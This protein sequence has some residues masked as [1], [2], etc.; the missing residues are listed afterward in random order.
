MSENYTMELGREQKIR[1]LMEHFQE[2]ERRSDLDRIDA[3]ARTLRTWGTAAH[4]KARDQREQAYEA[5]Q[6]AYERMSDAQLDDALTTNGPGA[7]LS[8]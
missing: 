7:P 3:D 5:W 1:F 2:D 4:R 6:K 8:R